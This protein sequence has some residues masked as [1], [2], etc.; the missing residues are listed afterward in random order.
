MAPQLKICDSPAELGELFSQAP[1]F[2]AVL[3]GPQHIFELANSAYYKLIGH[4]ELI[5]KAMIDVLPEIERQQF[6]ALLDRVLATGEPYV[7]TG[8]SVLLQRTAGGELEER[9]VD[10]VYQ[11]LISFD[12]SISGVFVEG[13]DVTDLKQA[14]NALKTADRHKDEFL[15]TLAHELRNPLAPIRHA[16]RI[17]QMPQ[18][19]SE[20]RKWSNTVIERQV[21]HMAR[22]LDDLLVVSRITCGRVEIHKERLNLNESVGAVLD[23]LRPQIEGRGR[24]LE[25]DLPAAPLYIDADPVRLPQ[26]IANIVTNAAKFTGENGHIRVVA[27]KNNGDHVTIRVLDNGIGISPEALPGVFEMFSQV[28]SALERSEGGLGI[29]LS[30]AKGFVLLHG[31]TIEAH[32][33]GLGHGSEFIITLPVAKH[34]HDCAASQSE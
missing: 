1:G 32:S 27:Q 4:R 23:T 15:A 7:G 22:L 24:Q 8:V 11:P 2:M 18:A 25:V 30:I 6:I 29:G 14:E 26:I 5:G 34:T 3:R 10:F 9:F 33:P 17:C 20:Q 16:V 12:N 31:G 28:T 21:Q 13:Y 19:T